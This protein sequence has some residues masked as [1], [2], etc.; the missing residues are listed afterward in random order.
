MESFVVVQFPRCKA[1][2]HY[3]RYGALTYETN[4]MP[5]I[6]ACTTARKSKMR[7]PWPYTWLRTGENSPGYERT[8]ADAVQLTAAR[9]H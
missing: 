3:C 9:M 8:A 4:S 6:F 5:L 7:T 1:T 2:A